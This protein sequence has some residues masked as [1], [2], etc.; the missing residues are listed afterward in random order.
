MRFRLDIITLHLVLLFW[1]RWFSST[2]HHHDQRDDLQLTA[3]T[4]PPFVLEW[5]PRIKL[6]KHTW[7]LKGPLTLYSDQRT[8][9]CV[10]TTVSNYIATSLMRIMLRLYCSNMSPLKGT[11]SFKG[12]VTALC[13]ILK[14]FSPN[15]SV[16]SNNLNFFEGGTP[17]PTLV[18]S[19]QCLHLQTTADP[20]AGT[21]SV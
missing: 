3:Y 14:D 13:S 16:F 12:S 15:V 1:L 17:V 19:P 7:S 2:Y 10:S 5:S 18:W 8:C 21:F 6:I 11:A 20:C 4:R 9:A